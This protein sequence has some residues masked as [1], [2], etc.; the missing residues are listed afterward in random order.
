MLSCKYAYFS[1]YQEKQLKEN[2]KTDGESNLG[3]YIEE[4]ENHQKQLEQICEH[5]C[6]KA[7]EALGHCT[8]QWNTVQYKTYCAKYKVY[9]LIKTDTFRLMV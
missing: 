1:H 9:L 8:S 3:A 7:D 6:K 2:N 5:I 4:L